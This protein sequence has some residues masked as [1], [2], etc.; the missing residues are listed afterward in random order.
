MGGNDSWRRIKGLQGDAKTG[1]NEAAKGV[2]DLATG[3][4]TNPCFLCKSWEKDERKL[5]QHFKAHNLIIE[6]DGTIETPIIKD[7]PQRRTMKLKIQQMGWCRRDCVPTDDLATCQNFNQ[8][9]QKAYMRS[10]LAL[11]NRARG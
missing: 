8:V 1:G 3:L 5:V 7:D 11:V 4:E 6:P 10:R 2:V 9:K